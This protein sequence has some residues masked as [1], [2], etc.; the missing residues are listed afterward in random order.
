MRVK[1]AREAS[2]EAKRKKR[3]EQISS[4]GTHVNTPRRTNAHIRQSDLLEA[5][6]N[7]QYRTIAE[8]E[9]TRS[10][11]TRNITSG[12]VDI[13]SSQE[14]QIWPPPERNEVHVHRILTEDVYNE[15]RENDE[16]EAKGRNEIEVAQVPIMRTAPK[17]RARDIPYNKPLPLPGNKHTIICVDKYKLDGIQV[18]YEEWASEIGRAHV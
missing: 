6:K 9:R 3:A 16:D 12:R 14:D 18:P 8:K 10:G 11:V 13:Q 1:K 15:M 2:E 17:V 7:E 4:K 5:T